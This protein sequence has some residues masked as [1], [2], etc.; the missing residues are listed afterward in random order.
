MKTMSACLACGL[1]LAVAAPGRLPGHDDP[2]AEEKEPNLLVNGSFEEGPDPKTF[3]WFNEGATDI[4]G[5]TVSRGQL[6]YV[7]AYWQ[8]ADGKR[9]LDM[10]GGPGFGGIKQTFKTKKGQ[11]YRVSFSLAGNPLGLV[12][13]KELGVSAAGKEEKFTFDTTGKTTTDMG[14][15]N[16]A[17]DF[18]AT[19]AE[20]TLEFYTTM[21][22]DGNCGP[23]LD[24]VSVKP[25][26]E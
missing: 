2:P 1:V 18:V 19:G 16:Q 3:V 5:W 14:W 6:S 26:E 9:S 17:W 4:K 21:T 23:A 15:T 13:T 20:T 11:K 24:K 7:S 12:A 22:E 25:V 8:H 10:H